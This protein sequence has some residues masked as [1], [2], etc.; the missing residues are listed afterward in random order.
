MSQ[1]IKKC[2]YSVNSCHVFGHLNQPLALLKAWVA[3]VLAHKLCA[4]SHAVQ[5]WLLN[6]KINTHFLCRALKI[7]EKFL[8][9]LELRAQKRLS[10]YGKGSTSPPFLLPR[11]EGKVFFPIPGGKDH[12]LYEG[13][14]SCW[15]NS[16]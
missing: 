9:L 13:R 6:E 4:S 16:Q 7:T 14:A 1:C 10:S 11:E 15:T 5:V 2:D 12:L 8:C 3:L